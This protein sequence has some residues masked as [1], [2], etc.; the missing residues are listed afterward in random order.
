MSYVIK[1]TLDDTL[2]R[3]TLGNQ[4]GAPGGLTFAQLES[5]VRQL[6]ELP[7]SS[8]LKLTYVDSDNDV[9]TM[10]NDVD[11]KDACVGQRLNPLRLKAFHVQKED[12]SM[13]NQAQQQGGG[14]ANQT[15]A[16]TSRNTN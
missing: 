16:A 7:A 2:R 4:P 3:L 12:R 6:F 5:Q 13:H 11:L 10:R 15:A 14:H 9:V 8:K 1:V